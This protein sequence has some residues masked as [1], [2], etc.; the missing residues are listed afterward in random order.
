[1]TFVLGSGEWILAKPKAFWR[2]DPPF[3]TLKI[4][5]DAKTGTAE[6][7]TGIG[8]PPVTSPLSGMSILGATKFKACYTFGTNAG[9]LEGEIDGN[10]RIDLSFTGTVATS[11]SAEP[12]RTRPPRAL[13]EAL[14]RFRSEAEGFAN[15]N[16]TDAATR[17]QY[18]ANSRKYARSILEDAKKGKLAPADACRE[19]DALRNAL[20]GLGVAAN[21]LPK[22]QAAAKAG[23]A[24]GG[25]RW[26]HLGTMTAMEAFGNPKLPDSAWVHFASSEVASSIRTSGVVTS[27]KSSWARWGEVKNFTY[28]KLVFQIGSMSTSAESDLGIMAVAPEGSAIREVKGLYGFKVEGEASATVRAAQVVESTYV[29]S[30][31]AA[32]QA[33]GK[34][35]AELEEIYAVKRYA[36][37]IKGRSD[38]MPGVRAFDRLTKGEQAQVRLDIIES[39]RA[40]TPNPRPTPPAPGKWAKI[41]KCLLVISIGI[42]IYKVATAEDKLKQAAREAVGFAGGA[43]AGLA[44]GTAVSA[45]APQ[46][47]PLIIGASVFVGGLLGALGADF[48]FDWADN[49]RIG[50]A[51]L[52]ENY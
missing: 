46:A 48:V 25:H 7:G 45:Y 26:G 42:S 36:E 30:L 24:A 34:A 3:V 5:F 6:Q 28:G 32:E 31:A 39:I 52:E 8:R 9:T 43:A 37:A 49:L 44:V 47:S 29:K 19:V 14:R 35:L 21:L 15:R 20:A 23:A 22:L 13:T 17:Q 1:M 50:S 51:D 16:L 4:D 38:G 10:R 33:A 41:G 40:Q 11:C 2:S 18:L 12:I 27:S